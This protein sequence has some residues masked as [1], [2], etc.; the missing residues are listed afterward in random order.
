MVHWISYAGWVVYLQFSTSN[1]N[2]NSRDTL[3]KVLYIFSFLHQTTTASV[4]FT[5]FICCI[6]LVFYIK[7]QPGERT[8]EVATKLYIFSFLH[9]TTTGYLS[10][11]THQRCISLVFYIKPQLITKM[12]HQRERCISLVFY[13]KPQHPRLVHLLDL[14]VYLQFSTSN[15]NFTINNL[16]YG[17][18]V[19]LQFSTSNHN[20]QIAAASARVLYIFSFLHQTTTLT[21]ERKTTEQLYIFSFLHQT[22]TIMR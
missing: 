21:T 19:Y 15:H 2:Q 10:A 12:K 11:C 8:T 22:T 9:Q 1:H 20:S 16:L 7:P 17:K 13:I 14:V 6:S 18:V 5:A 3:S 4:R